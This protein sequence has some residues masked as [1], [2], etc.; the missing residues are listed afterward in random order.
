L[1]A[2]VGAGDRAVGDCAG[3]GFRIVPRGEEDGGD[4]VNAKRSVTL[5]SVLAFGYVFLYLP[6]AILIVY[7]FNDSQ[8]VTVWS[9]ASL[10]WYF[11]LLKN[12]QLQEAAWLSLRIAAVSATIAAVLG[13]AAAF[14]LQRLRPFAGSR[15]YEALVMMPLVIPEVLIG[16]SLLL[17]FVVLGATIG[18]PGTRGA[19]TVTLAHATFSMAYATVVVRARLSQLDPALEEAAAILGAKPWRAFLKVTLPL[20]MPAIAAAWLLAFTLSLDDVVVASFVTGPG[21]STLPIVVFSSV[22][23]GV[24]PQINALATLIVVFVACLILAATFMS[25]AGAKT[26]L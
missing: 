12:T 22:R 15:S 24:S 17:L 21:A 10:R 8:L 5:L 6:I 11:A 23:L 9:H 20:L 1:A 2:C 4:A 3:A 13:T 25:R 7:S 14:A 16:L 18:W 19:T 26:K